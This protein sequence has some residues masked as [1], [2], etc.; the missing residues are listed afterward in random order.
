MTTFSFNLND[1]VL[2]WMGLLHEALPFVALGALLSGVVDVYVSRETVTRI[3]PRN[4]WAA[5]PLSALLGLGVP[6]CECGIV[7]V[8]RRFIRKGVPISCAVTYMLAAPIVHPLVIVSTLMAFRGQGAVGMTVLRLGLGIAIAMGIGWAVW[9]FYGEDRLVLPDVSAAASIGDPQGRHTVPAGRRALLALET[10]ASD[11]VEFGGFL[12]LGTGIASVIN[13]GFSHAALA[14]IAGSKTGS[15]A[16]MMLL[17]VLLNLC[18]EADAFVAAAF[19]L[20]SVPAKISFLV[21]GPMLD[22]KLLLMFGAVFR[23]RAILF[24]CGMMI[25]LVFIACRFGGT[26]MMDVVAWL[27]K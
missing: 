27:P 4:P 25:G 20:F 3:V 24:L 19:T 15:I 7:P 22:V 16:A 13:S 2:T 9:I 6:M 26:W 12:I 10:A 1:F 8:V 23:R 14:P 17:A 11:L 18:S 5:V 21:L